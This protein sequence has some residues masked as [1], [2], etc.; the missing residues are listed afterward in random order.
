MIRSLCSLA[1]KNAYV[2]HVLTSE[3]RKKIRKVDHNLSSSSFFYLYLSIDIDIKSCCHGIYRILQTNILMN[4]NLSE[5][6]DDLS[7]ITDLDLLKFQL[8]HQREK[9]FSIIDLLI[10]TELS[11]G[12]IVLRI[13]YDKLSSD[14]NQFNEEYHILKTEYQH[15][16]HACLY[17]I[18]KTHD[19]IDE[20]NKYYHEWQINKSRLTPRPDWDKVS[21]VID[22]KIER[23]KS[24][25]TGK[26]SEQLVEIL[27]KEIVNGNQ[28]ETLKEEEH[29]SAIGDD[30]TVLPFLRM[31][32]YTRIVNRRMRRRMTGLLIQEI[33]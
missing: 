15:L 1:N 19:L 2:H 22:G 5:F 4:T 26:S 25:S 27:M 18:N 24:L 10:K 3:E 28:T 29:F 6:E 17:L 8:I 33:W 31:P 13:D 32:K 20:R 9:L 21:N 11:Y 12:D 7:S 16:G 23:W 30:L 14:Q